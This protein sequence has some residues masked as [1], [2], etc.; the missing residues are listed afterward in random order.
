V[1]FLVMGL[2]AYRLL[3]VDLQQDGKAPLVFSLLVYGAALMLL[4]RLMQSR[5]AAASA[6]T[7]SASAGD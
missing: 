5:R 4:P 7:A 3:L 1:V 6:S 2:A